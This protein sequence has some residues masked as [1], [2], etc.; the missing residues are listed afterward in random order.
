[1]KIVTIGCE[2]SASPIKL[3]VP[4]GNLSCIQ[5]G[6]IQVILSPS[7]AAKI[8]RHCH[9]MH[10]QVNLG[11]LN[12]QPSFFITVDPSHVDLRGEPIGTWLIG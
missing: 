1:M 7:Q 8:R 2:H 12:D 10:A 5:C 3:R 6:L 11:R 4:A 9:C